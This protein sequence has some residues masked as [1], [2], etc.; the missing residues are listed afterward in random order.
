M[1][2]IF[3]EKIGKRYKPIAEYDSEYSDSFTKGTHLVMCYPGGVS[4][5][6][7][8]DPNYAAM[9]AASRVAND[10]ICRAISKASEL[11]PVNQMTTA[12]QRAAW[13]NLSKEFG[14]ELSTLYGLSI[15]DCAQ[16]GVNAMMA[17]AAD[18]LDNPTVKQA[19]EQFLLVAELSRTSPAN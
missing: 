6:F 13:D 4:R 10:A 1:K 12:G 8:I 2:K 9:I 15:S 19:F 3:Y 14:S 16:A 7:N 5:K 17:E 11:R 18:M